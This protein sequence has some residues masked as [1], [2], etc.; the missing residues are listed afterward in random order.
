[1]TPL[2]WLWNSTLRLQGQIPPSFPSEKT[3]ILGKPR[4]CR[5]G[6]DYVAYDIH[7][8]LQPTMSQALSAPD[9]QSSAQTKPALQMAQ[10]LLLTQSCLPQER[11]YVTNS[12]R[13]VTPFQLTHYQSSLCHQHRKSLRHLQAA[14]SCTGQEQPG[15]RAMGLGDAQGGCNHHNTG[16]WDT[17]N[18]L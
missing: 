15:N 14:E 18:S 4:I 3:I 2:L 11:K 13:E 6:E 17:G 12:K 8:G 1:M 16:T 5:W 10:Q 7:S 9:Q